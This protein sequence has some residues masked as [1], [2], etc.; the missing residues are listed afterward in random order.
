MKLFMIN[1]KA[2]F[3]ADLERYA[4][5]TDLQRFIVA[6]EKC[7]HGAEAREALRKAATRV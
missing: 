4:E 7:V 5:A 3:R 1:D 2:A 6:H